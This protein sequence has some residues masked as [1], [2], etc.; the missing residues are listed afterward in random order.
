MK[1]LIL[2]ITAAAVIGTNLSANDF[3]ANLQ[4]Q[5]ELS[6]AIKD[7]DHYYVQA[8]GGQ[9]NG[10]NDYELKMGLR[11][12]DY[13]LVGVSDFSFSISKEKQW[14]LNAKHFTAINENWSAYLGAGFE[15]FNSENEEKNESEMKDNFYLEA[16]TLTSLGKSTVL[17]TGVLFGAERSAATAEIH[18]TISKNVRA[19]VK[20]Q[21]SIDIENDNQNNVQ[22]G[23][24]ISF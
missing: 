5:A 13:S 15:R 18:Y 3:A 7:F 11:E 19:L 17:T 12:F 10:I 4:K 16:G 6:K 24:E 8:L 21:Y 1:K 23:L 22:T 14:D 2:G 20:Y 9:K